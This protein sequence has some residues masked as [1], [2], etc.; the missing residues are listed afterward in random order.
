MLHFYKDAPD[1]TA[2]KLILEPL[3]QYYEEARGLLKELPED[4]NVWLDNKHLIAETGSGGFAYGPDIMNVAF[5]VDFPDRVSQLRDLRATIFHEGY[6]LVQG[7]TYEDPKVPYA[8]ALDSVIYEGCATVFER[9]HA[10]INPLWGIYSQYDEATLA[11]WQNELAQISN[12]AYI[13]PKTQ[14]WQKWSFFDKESGERWRAYK[15]GTWLVDRAL[16]KSGKDILDLRTLS[17]EEIIKL[18]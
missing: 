9:E 14:L 10:D 5:D 1:I 11:E 18:S 16:Q 8:R 7:H 15:V 3:T 4:L 12:E 6:H 13:D 2:E 17:A